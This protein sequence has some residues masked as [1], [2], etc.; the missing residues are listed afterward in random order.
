VTIRVDIDRLPAEVIDAID[1]G[2][3]VEFARSGRVRSVARPEN[4]PSGP[5][6]WKAMSELEPLDRGLEED[7]RSLDAVVEPQKSAWES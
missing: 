1:R 7:I 6:L 4:G 5:D 2:D 3:T